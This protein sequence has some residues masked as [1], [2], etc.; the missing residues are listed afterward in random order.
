M[1]TAV[2]LPLF[3]V[4]EFIT[5]T[6]DLSYILDILNDVPNINRGGCGISA[7][8]IYRWCKKNNVEVSDRPFIILGDEWDIE[9]NK[10]HIKNGNINEIW[11]VHITIEIDGVIYDSKGD[12]AISRWDDYYTQDY[13]LSED[14][15]LELINNSPWNSEFRR[16]QW[17][18]HIEEKL[19]IDLSDVKIF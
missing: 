11:L 12:G 7:L 8:A 10:H 14:E 9:Q 4:S 3:N 13:Q 1:E 18:H 19:A 15:M 6:H 5:E 17:V 2:Q 16:R